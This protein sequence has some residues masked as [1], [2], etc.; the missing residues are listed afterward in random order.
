MKITNFELERFF[1]KFEFS[2]PHLLCCSDCETLSV[3]ELLALGEN[4]NEELAGLR[5]GYTESAGHPALRDAVSDMYVRTT[6]EDVLVFSGAEEGIFVLM[7]ALLERGDH[8]SVQFPAYQSLFEV[9]RAIGCDFSRWTLEE[10]RGWRPN[11]DLL[12]DSI[13]PETKLIVINFPHNPTGS[14]ATQEEYEEIIGIARE[15]EILLFSDEVYRLS[16]YS[17]ADRLDAMC[18]LYEHGISLGV[19]S[20]SLGL[21]GLR[22]G[23]LATRNR[24]VINKCAAYKDYTTICNSAPSELLATFA[25]SRREK[26]LKR[27]LGIIQ[28]NLELLDRF[29]AEQEG[30]LEWV[31]PKAGPIAFPRLLAGSAEG[32]C[33]DLIENAGVLLLPST[34]FEYGDSHFRIG[35]GRA[36]MPAC[37][38]VLSDFLCR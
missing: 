32:F 36:D 35:F 12:K 23:W 25:L 13:R 33:L 2:A 5:L 3:A 27:N 22:I 18:D 8:L 6:T 20:K 10:E 1:A 34:K 4:Y 24:N 16:E 26:I 30:R 28:S 17:Q 38:G 15:R 21:A 7:N 31:R 29:F 9:A 37:L 11:L 19:M 14:L